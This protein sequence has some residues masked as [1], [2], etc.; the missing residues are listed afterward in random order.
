MAISLI[1][2]IILYLSVVIAIRI[3]GKRQIGEL[4]PTELV[5]MILVSELAAIPMQDSGIPLVAGLIPIIMLI[6]M[7]ILLS[8]F[9]LKSI[10]LRDLISGKPCVIIRHGKIDRKKLGEMRVNADEIL[11]ELRL[12]NIESV[13][14][15]KYGIIETNGR[16]SFVFYNHAKPVNAGLL[17]LSPP[18]TGIPLVVVSDGRYIDENIQ[19]LKKTNEWIEKQIQKSHLTSVKDVF[20]MTLDDAGNQFIQEKEG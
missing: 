18:D 8:Y 9:C 4:E 19:K 15:V 12:Q 1:R 14:D 16:M 5:V 10:K 20:I 17:S 13:K 7:E 2:T 11:Q 6:S 3:M